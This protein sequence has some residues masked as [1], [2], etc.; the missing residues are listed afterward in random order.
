LSES[1]ELKLSSKLPQSI[2]T[3]GALMKGPHGKNRLKGITL[4][5]MLH[6]TPKMRHVYRFI[7]TSLA[8]VTTTFGELLGALGGMGYD[9]T[10]IQHW[11][12]SVRIRSLTIWPAATAVGSASVCT[13]EWTASSGETAHIPDDFC[14]KATPAGVTITGALIYRP[15]VRSLASDWL[16]VGGPVAVTDNVLSF[17]NLASGSVLDLDV[18]FTLGV[19]VSTASALHRSTVST[20][21]LGSIYYL[22]LD[23]PSGKIVP[24]TG[25]PTTN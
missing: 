22:D 11:A 4:P 3:Y 6:S 1:K 20:A 12:S 16:S 17:V 7:V 24:V 15:P 10:H 18:E 19:C 8:N 2:K 21:T 9:S 23:G 5:P 25:I 13:V 14:E